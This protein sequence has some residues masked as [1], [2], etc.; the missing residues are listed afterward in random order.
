MGLNSGQEV[1]WAIGKGESY[2]DGSYV[3]FRAKTDDGSL[4]AVDPLP[5]EAV[6]AALVKH[7]DD[8]FLE[9][10]IQSFRFYLILHAS[11]GHA[12][13]RRILP[14]GASAPLASPG[15]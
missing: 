7:G 5:W 11:H 6:R 8:F 12:V 3:E 14:V 13:H 9:Q 10:F 4:H 15:G 2:Q 1:G